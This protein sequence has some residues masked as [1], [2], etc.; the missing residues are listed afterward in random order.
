MYARIK[1]KAPG[2]TYFS[3]QCHWTMI[4]HCIDVSESDTRDFLESPG[5]RSISGVQQVAVA[6]ESGNVHCSQDGLERC[7]STCRPSYSAQASPPCL[8][9]EDQTAL[10]LPPP[11]QPACLWMPYFLLISLE[12]GWHRELVTSSAALTL[13]AWARE[14]ALCDS[15]VHVPCAEYVVLS[16]GS[17]AHS[18][19]VLNVAVPVYDTVCCD[20]NSTQLLLA[21]TKDNQ[22]GSNLRN[23]DTN[24]LDGCDSW[25]Y[26]LL[27]VTVCSQWAKRIYPTSH[28]HLW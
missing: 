18:H 19:L 8:Y 9:C 11:S 3:R 14:G 25:E 23:T 1:M 6:A 17:T 13:A 12:S 22:D 26:P 5:G 15:A 20:G 2:S 21:H 4:Q 7:S 27:V 10:A 28:A 24:I 16:Q